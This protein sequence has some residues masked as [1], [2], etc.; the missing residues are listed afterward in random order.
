M[1]NRLTERDLSR[2][3]RRVINEQEDPKNKLIG[4]LMSKL[5]SMKSDPNF[6]AD[7]VCEVIVNNCNHYKNKTD[8]FSN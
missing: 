4:V 5:T 1:R 6:D 7:S 3:V 2:I 8:I